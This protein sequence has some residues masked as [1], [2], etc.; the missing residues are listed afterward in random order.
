MSIEEQ[1]QSCEEFHTPSKIVE[2]Y[3]IN[4]KGY[5]DIS[6]CVVGSILNLL[7]IIVFTRK[8][9]ISPVNMIFTHLAWADLLMLLLFIPY[10][11]FECFEEYTNGGWTYQQ[12]FWYIWLGNVP[13]IFYFMSVFLTVMLSVWRHIAI[14]HPL[15]ERQWCS[16]KMT[17]NVV[18]AGYLTSVLLGIPMYFSTGIKHVGN[19][20]TQIYIPHAVEDSNLFIISRI[21]NSVLYQLLPAIA[22]P[23]FSYKLIIVLRAKKEHQ[24]YQNPSTDI[25]NIRSTRTPEMRNKSDRSIVLLL[26]VMALHLISKLPA[27][28]IDLLYLTYGRANKIAWECYFNVS[29]IFETMSCVTLSVT[30]VIY[31]TMGNHFRITFNSLFIRKKCEEIDTDVE[32]EY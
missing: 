28:I 15:K 27:G 22:L 14:V 20:Q 32:S 30:F 8:N 19:N 23:I 3:L 7:N 1:E 16:M 31:Y 9:M 6:I 29:V 18:I 24:Q 4:V 5:V 13:A 25:N 12:T 17:R 11:W 2:Y 10:T 21:I 26:T